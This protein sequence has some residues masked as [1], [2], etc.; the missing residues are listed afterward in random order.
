MKIYDDTIVYVLAPA[1]GYTGGIE[2]LHQMVSQLLSLGCNTKLVYLA[3]ITDPPETPV[4][5]KYHLQFTNDIHDN[6]HNIFI[7]PETLTEILS[8]VCRMPRI[9][10]LELLFVR[11]GAICL[12]LV[13]WI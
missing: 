6:N 9:L 4:Y 13:G 1:Y 11:T 12:L 8:K 2:L 7:V 3:D 5:K 10:F